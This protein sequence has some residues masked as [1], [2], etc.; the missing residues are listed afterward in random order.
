MLT[1]KNAVEPA[2]EP[3][4]QLLKALA[5]MLGLRPEEVTLSRLAEAESRA[6]RYYNERHPSAKYKTLDASIRELKKAARLK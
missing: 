1:K 6:N 5:E 3:D 4:A 2:D